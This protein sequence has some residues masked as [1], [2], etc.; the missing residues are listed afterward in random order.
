MKKFAIALLVLV[1][2]A[3]PVFAA[4]INGAIDLDG[5][6]AADK[7]A[8]LKSWEEAEKKSVPVGEAVIGDVTTESP[9]VTIEEVDVVGTVAKPAKMATVEKIVCRSEGLKID[10]SSVKFCSTLSFRIA[11]DAS[12]GSI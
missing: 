8:L 6:K 5:S 7:A 1:S 9:V 12:E 11:V 3:L 2:V 10:N 4:G